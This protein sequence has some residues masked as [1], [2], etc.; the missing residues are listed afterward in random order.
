MKFWRV[1][2]ELF[3]KNARSKSLSYAREENDDLCFPSAE[4]VKNICDRACVLDHGRMMFIGKAAEAIEHRSER[5]AVKIKSQLTLLSVVKTYSEQL[6]VFWI[7]TANYAPTSTQGAAMKKIPFRVKIGLMV[8]LATLT[9]GCFRHA[10]EQ[11]DSESRTIKVEGIPAQ[12]SEPTERAPGVIVH[13][14]PKTGEII[15]P[16]TGALPGE[17]PQAPVDTTK[18]PPA[19]LRE[20][21]SPV[22]GGGVV[23]H[24]DERFDTPLTATIDADG[25]I[26]LE[27]KRTMSASEDKK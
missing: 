16:S 27:H 18:K 22:P 3:Q 26:K 19:E 1:G 6:G 8:L 15:T 25:N 13:I 24:L 21:P 12:P 11:V 7:L 5:E 4:D 10:S 9:A 17:V 14:D 20:V 2:G 23:I